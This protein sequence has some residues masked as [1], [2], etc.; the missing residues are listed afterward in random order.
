[1]QSKYEPYEKLDELKLWNNDAII[2]QLD[3]GEKI[4][5][6]CKINKHNKYDAIQLRSLLITNR[7]IYN[8]DLDDVLPY[9]L[10]FIY[11]KAIIKRKIAI[12]SIAG[13][14][15]SSYYL[16]EEF[17]IH[18]SK[19][20]DYRFSCTPKK[21]EVI[22]KTICKQ[23]RLSTG[24]KMPFYIKKEPELSFFQ[25]TDDDLKAGLNKMPT[26]PPLMLSDEDLQLGLDHFLKL[27]ANSEHYT[28]SPFRTVNNDVDIGTY[29]AVPSEQD[30]NEMIKAE[31]PCEN[32][33]FVDKAMLSPADLSGANTTYRAT[34]QEPDIQKHAKLDFSS[35]LKFE[36]LKK[37]DQEEEM[38]P[39]NSDNGAGYP[40][41]SLQQA[42]YQQ[43][44][45]NPNPQGYP[46]PKKVDFG[47]Y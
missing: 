25:T 30:K 41:F 34:F 8:L 32:T 42:Q 21:R 7:Y 24:N 10:S 9:L 38:R 15:V 14:T 16:S 45:Y 2:G 12:P 39:N 29:K 28:R 43:Y 6:S 5:L 17:V 27:K 4:I 18:V 11:P 46:P 22:L 20:Y 13:I 40:K 26:E 36:D 44:V 23:Y 31:E 33:Y 3:P 1:M 37:L 47:K 35:Q 19:A